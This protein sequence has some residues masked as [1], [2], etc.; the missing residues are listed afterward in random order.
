MSRHVGVG[1]LVDEL[2]DR[3]DRLPFEIGAF[4]AL[5]TCEGLLRDSVRVAADDVWVTAEG[6][7]VVSEQAE[8]TDQVQAARSLVSLLSRLL[9][10]AGPGVPPHL[11]QLVEEAALPSRPEDLQRLHDAIEASLV[12][13]N[14]GAS[15]RVLARLV[16][17]SERPAMLE[18]PAPAVGELD[19]A[20]DALLGESGPLGSETTESMEEALTSSGGLRAPTALQADMLGMG[21]ETSI[22]R[23]PK[24]RE[25]LVVE[26]ALEPVTATITIAPA[27]GAA[28]A[29]A[30]EPLSGAEDASASAAE[31]V[32]E[33][34]PVVEPEPAGVSAR[35][36]A[37]ASESVSEIAPV[38][39]SMSETA[40]APVRDS[41]PLTEEGLAESVSTARSGP[42]SATDLTGSLGR[43]S[44]PELRLSG[45][46]VEPAETSLSSRPRRAAP[47][48]ALLFVA[49]IATLVLSIQS[50]MFESIVG[51]GGS[52]SAPTPALE[53]GTIEVTVLPE[54]A[55][56]FLFEGRGPVP[57]SNLSVRGPHEFLVFDNGV[58]AARAV[59]PAGASWE[60]APDGTPLYELAVQAKA[61]DLG[62]D[63]PELVD[64]GAA[65][66]TA[67]PAQGEPSGTVRVI[68]NPPG[69]KVFR[70]LG[71]GPA[72]QVQ[73]RSIHEG[74]EL[75]VFHPGHEPQ[76]ALVGPSD[77]KSVPGRGPV[78]S[79]ELRLPEIPAQ[80]QP[81]P[82]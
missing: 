76:R 73:A 13:I 31:A 26:P 61:R 55:Q 82:Q 45:P 49:L 7:V 25:S 41:E 1:Q 65:L 37:S 29:Q 46:P 56:V 47:W 64:L 30:A 67:V 72:L 20:L 48:R 52:S 44:Q 62:A 77:W 4:V 79:V 28:E 59:V 5:E 43:V 54:G 40:S 51:S 24:P 53:T 50:G 57:V 60:S 42:V 38:S 23:M 14:R 3:G 35:G 71:S 18:A 11:L 8:R 68:T 32:S 34:E 6:A 39:E 17:E 19:A 70:L 81:P 36:A 80:I 33:V 12:P 66:T 74:Q 2:R 69:A 15:R 58:Q 9:V 78:A 16:R 63:T 75:L 10:A 27:S 22:Y 21:E